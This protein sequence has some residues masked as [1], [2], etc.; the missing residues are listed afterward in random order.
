VGASRVMTLCIGLAELREALFYSEAG[1]CFIEALDGT[2]EQLILRKIGRDVGCARD[3][4]DCIRTFRI[5]ASHCIGWIF[6]L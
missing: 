3:I 1:C 4:G 5:G 2:D 6:L